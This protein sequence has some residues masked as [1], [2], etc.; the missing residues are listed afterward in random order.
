MLFG[1]D[2]MKCGCMLD[3]ETLSDGIYSSLHHTFMSYIYLIAILSDSL[4]LS[5]L[6][7][8]NTIPDA[9]EIPLV[10]PQWSSNPFDLY[11]QLLFPLLL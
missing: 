10:Y 3:R 6:V 5:L 8:I 4:R 2:V 9:D 11:S 1:D 7:L